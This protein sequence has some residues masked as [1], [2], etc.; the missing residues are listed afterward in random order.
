[1]AYQHVVFDV[2]GTLIDTEQPVLT[3]LQMT[4]RELLHREMPL[5]ELKFSYGIPGHEALVMLGAPDP[6]AAQDLWNRHLK[7]L[8]GAVR[9]FDGVRQTLEAL[10]KRGVRMG[11]ITS[12]NREEYE[13][14]FT[15]FGLNGYFDIS[16]TA[17]DTRLHKPNPD[18]L[19]RYRE[20]TG[21]AAKETLYVGDSVYDM[22]C[23]A[24][25]GV[26]SGLA[27]WG[28]GGVRHS[29]ATYCFSRPQEILEALDR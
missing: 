1:M 21:A 2:D 22:R 25:A 13:T 26:D 14:D 15:P 24:S 3:A 28:C 5:S 16:L 8:F 17:D 12:K 10:R 29:P 18:P 7:E 4:V 9:I 27:L 20:L 23:A 11:I 19:N 6:D